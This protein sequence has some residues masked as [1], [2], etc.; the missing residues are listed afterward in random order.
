MIYK[1]GKIDMSLCSGC[2]E[3]RFSS[4]GVTSGTTASRKIQILAI[5]TML[6]QL[7]ISGFT[8]LQEGSFY[9][10]LK[11]G[12]DHDDVILHCR[13]ISLPLSGA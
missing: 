10:E 4:S 9:D 3:K 5:F 12:Y 1:V 7:A 11:P 13:T 2:C 8:S 6:V